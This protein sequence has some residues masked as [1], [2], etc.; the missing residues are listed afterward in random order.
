MNQNLENNNFSQINEIGIDGRGQTNNR[1]TL[2]GF[3]DLIE[4][5]SNNQGDNSNTEERNEDIIPLQEE[6]D[7]NTPPSYSEHVFQLIL[8][9]LFEILKKAYL[10]IGGIKTVLYKKCNFL[11]LQKAPYIIPIIKQNENKCK[12]TKQIL[13]MTIAKYIEKEL[14]D[15]EAKKHGNR[16]AI[17]FHRENLEEVLNKILFL[18]FK[19]IENNKKQK[20][21]SNNESDELLKGN[22]KVESNRNNNNMNSINFPYD[23]QTTIEQTI[24]GIQ[25]VIE[26]APDNRPDNLF[27]IVKSFT[28]ESFIIDFNKQVSKNNRLPTKIP[29]Y[30]INIKG[31]SKNNSFWNLSFRDN[32]LYFINDGEE[33]ERIESIIRKLYKQK[34]KNKKAIELLE[35]SPLEYI[36]EKFSCEEE[37]KAFLDEDK[38]MKIK[39][40]KNK[41]CKT[42]YQALKESQIS[43]IK[44]LEKLI[45]K[46]NQKDEYLRIKDP[47]EFIKEVNKIEGYEDLN[48]ELTK[49]ENAKINERL[50]ILEEL[51]NDPILYLA[52]IKERKLKNK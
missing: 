10:S 20:E 25:M 46:N 38:E 9:I 3:N 23:N 6:E 16:K 19:A 11:L 32:F 34:D 37:K 41:K 49:E 36:K 30:L 28:N 48:L 5:I 43:D 8:R 29:N 45:I 12:K 52:S 50:E 44:N 14:K 17:H 13:N 40:I 51:A 4:N 2:N 18:H 22:I 26:Y 21:E 39:E 7:N 24:K 15:Y 47:D 42:I 31:K 33:K 35:K 27:E 1:G